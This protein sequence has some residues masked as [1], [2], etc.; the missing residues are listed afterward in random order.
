[1]TTTA[2][3]P[4]GISVW[5]ALGLP[6]IHRMPQGWIIDHGGRVV[7]VPDVEGLVRLLKETRG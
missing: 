4:I 6:S 5:K 7:I 1:M 3:K 2:R